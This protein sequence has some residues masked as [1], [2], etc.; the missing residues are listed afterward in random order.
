MEKLQNLLEKIFNEKKET[1]LSNNGQ[2]DLKILETLL[3]LFE[4]ARKWIKSL[5]KS[6][7]VGK[8]CPKISKNY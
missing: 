5:Q 1:L 4:N 3:K 6:L 7:I 8:N 2:N